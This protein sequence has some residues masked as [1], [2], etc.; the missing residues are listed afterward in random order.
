ME[1]RMLVEYKVKTARK[2]RG[3]DVAE[4]QTLYAVQKGD[5]FFIWSYTKRDSAVYI[6][7]KT[8]GPE[9]K[10]DEAANWRRNLQASEA[11]E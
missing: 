4:G 5:L 3:T 7:E 8:S 10:A 1:S 11:T 2:V 6:D 9:S